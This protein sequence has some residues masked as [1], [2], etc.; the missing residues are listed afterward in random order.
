MRGLMSAPVIGTC[1]QSGRVGV[2]GLIP[3]SIH[4]KPEAELGY[5]LG[6]VT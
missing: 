6:S 5:R 2:R 1:S 4:P 3:K